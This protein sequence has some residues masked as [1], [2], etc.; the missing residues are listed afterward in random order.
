VYGQD[1]GIHVW[2]TAPSGTAGNAITF[3]QAMT[4]LNN[5]NVGIGT[6]SPQ[7][8]LSV[9]G[10]QN[11]T[12]IPANAVAK[13]VGGDAGIFV[14]NLAGTPNYGA[15]LQAMRESDAFVFPLSLQ[16]NGGN[17]GIG[18]TNPDYKLN[19]NSSSTYKALMLQANALGTRFD[20]ALEFNVI[21]VRTVPYARIG[22][23]VTSASSNDETG[24]LTFWTINSGTLSEKMSVAGGGAVTINNLATG[25]VTSSSGT[26][27]ATSDM[28]LKISDGYIDNA[29]DKIMNLKPRYFYW[30][31]ETGLP[32]NIRQLGFY[33]QEV[34]QSLGEEA[35]NTP[36]NENDKWGIYDR[37]IIAM[38]TKAI[39]EQ[40]SQ[41]DILKQEII[42]LKNK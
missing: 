5:G 41:I 28:N 22:L 19:I 27:S 9:Q 40:Q 26:L 12:I 6:A 16:P 14:G 42:N 32:T 29:L 2:Y 20:V 4:I 35:A 30:K 21:N 37:S 7:V 23:Q 18:T 10:T 38:L 15:W 11:N 25:T 13:F 1:D 34:N 33:A 17:V 31:E 3:T 24:G 39:Q 8:K 36:K